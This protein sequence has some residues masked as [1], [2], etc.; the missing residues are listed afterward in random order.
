MPI[1]KVESEFGRCCLP[2]S[3]YAVTTNVPGWD[4]VLAFRDG[5]P[6]VLSRVVHI[7]P[8]FGPFGC[9]G[10]VSSLPTFDTGP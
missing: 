9:V 8:R 6:S 5:D 10:G 7:Y 4:T 3:N 2:E 1:L